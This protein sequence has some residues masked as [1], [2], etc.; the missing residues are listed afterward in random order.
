MKRNELLKLIE[1]REKA[2]EELREEIAGRILSGVE[3][4]RDYKETCYMIE[5]LER[6][7]AN[8]RLCQDLLNLTRDDETGCKVTGFAGRETK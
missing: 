8:T 7:E 6:M 4:K 1:E 3:S 2:A 5:H